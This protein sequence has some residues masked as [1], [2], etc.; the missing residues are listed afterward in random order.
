MNYA[1]PIAE[2]RVLRPTLERGNISNVACAMVTRLHKL[3]RKSRLHKARLRRPSASESDH[4]PI[5]EIP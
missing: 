4:I 2:A 1:S 5:S 3:A